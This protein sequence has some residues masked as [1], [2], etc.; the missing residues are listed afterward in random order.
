[1]ITSIPFKEG[2]LVVTSI[3]AP[4]AVL[5]ALSEGAGRQGTRFIV[6][7]DDKSPDSFDIVGCEF[8]NLAR[9]R[10]LP[11]AYAKLG[12]ENSYTRKN[13]G[14]LLGL[15]EG[16]RF[17]VETD[18]DNFPREDFWNP[19]QPQVSGDLITREGWLNAYSYFSDTF[20]YPRGFPIE[21]A[22]TSKSELPERSGIQ[23]LYC[24][25]QQGLADRN[26]DVDAIYR[27]L[28]SLPLDFD[29]APPLILDNRTWCPFNSQ[30]TTTFREA[31]ALLYLP[32]FCSFRMTD[33]WRSFVAQRIAWTCDWRISFHSPTVYQERNEHDL[34]IDFRDEVAGYLHNATIVRTLNALELPQGTNHIYENMVS[35]YDALIDLKMVAPEERSLLAA[36]LEDLRELTKADVY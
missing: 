29:Q 17:I 15:A 3:S 28:F 25:I 14:Y 35:C 26:P 36:W 8:Y 23:K 13:I 12:P 9:Q 33:I 2:V 32:A 21:L 16:A 31:A 30:N 22:R 5:E 10:A 1:M 34:L 4:N 19:R 24:P 7:G 6:I 18:D 20:I 11:F 27:M